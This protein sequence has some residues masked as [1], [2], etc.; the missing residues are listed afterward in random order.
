MAAAGQ[1]NPSSVKQCC[2]NMIDF[3]E[4]FLSG[5]ISL[6]Q[7]RRGPTKVH[8]NHS[9]KIMF[10]TLI[11]SLL[12]FIKLTYIHRYSL[13]SLAGYPLLLQIFFFL[14]NRQPTI[15]TSLI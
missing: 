13:F 14:L 11:C 9:L 7:F 4:C 12:R 10:M 8:V 15:P 6:F 3:L 2:E 5:D 1:Q